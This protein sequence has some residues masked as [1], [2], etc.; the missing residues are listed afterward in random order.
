[1]YKLFIPL[2]CLNLLNPIMPY[3][4]SDKII[5]HAV[6]SSIYLKN[7]F[8]YGNN[9]IEFFI[10]NNI[11]LKYIHPFSLISPSGKQ[12]VHIVP[13]SL[14]INNSRVNITFN[15]PLDEHGIYQITFSG[16]D[17]YTNT[18]I[19]LIGQFTYN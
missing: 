4:Y 6:S 13:Q 16:V 3:S 10:P 1:M 12:L 7:I 11:K 2:I 18:Q 14:N 17:E 19:D 5:S 15:R 8:I 9:K